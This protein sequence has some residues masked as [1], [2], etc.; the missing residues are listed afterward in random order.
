[1]N[2]IEITVGKFSKIRV[3]L[4]NASLFAEIT[5]KLTRLP[6]ED[7]RYVGKE[8]MKFTRRKQPQNGTKAQEASI[9]VEISRYY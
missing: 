1:M 6:L 3:Y 4:A 5:V 7:K 2:G 9:R 8:T